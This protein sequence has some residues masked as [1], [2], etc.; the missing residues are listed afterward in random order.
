MTCLF[1]INAKISKDGLG[2]DDFSGPGLPTFNALCKK[3]PSKEVMLWI[4]DR[5]NRD[6]RKMLFFF[7]SYVVPAVMENIGS[8]FPHETEAELVRR[9][10]FKA[11]P[12]EMYTF[13]QLRIFI[14][15]IVNYFQITLH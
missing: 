8:F 2:L 4:E 14:D 12:L 5:E 13:R 11:I 7:R 1:R 9:F 15:S 10:G 6:T 3:H